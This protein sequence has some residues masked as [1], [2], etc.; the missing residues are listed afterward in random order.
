MR[1][2]HVS[3]FLQGGAGRIIAALAIAQ[4]RAGH[5][6]VVVADSGQHAGYE[7]YPEYITCLGEAGV[8]FHTVTSTFT[9]DVA[10]NVR[11][12]RELTEL[13]GDRPVDIA[14]THAAIPTLVAR[15]AL[16]ARATPL[17]QTMH[18]WGIRKTA[19]QAATD[20]TLL[21]LT[22]AVVTPSAA[23]RDTMLALGLRGTP[24][25]VVPYGLEEMPAGRAPDGTDRELFERLRA[26]GCPVVLCIGT[27]GERKNQ[28]LLVRALAS[29]DGVAAVFIGDGDSAPLTALARELDVASRV[30]VL[31]YRA[32][33]SRYL[34]LADA[35]V[36]PSR[37]EGLPIVVLEALRAGVPVVGSA[38][39]EIAEAVGDGQ[40]GFLFAPDDVLDL[41]A[42]LAGAL[43]PEVRGGVRA[44]ARQLFESRYR[45][46][47]MLAAYD[48]IYAQLRHQTCS[49][50]RQH[51]Q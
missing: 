17:L 44:R 12:V 15:L 41:A 47:R 51:V 4:R 36:L 26:S 48:E 28:A 6:V 29:L 20:I 46:D 2:L 40:T 38:I 24:V 10:L 32:D 16:S 23:A 35:L 25:H 50:E 19:E 27:I 34:P 37:N 11:A 18:G 33:A 8:R 30:H 43:A 5:D 21:G 39:P 1:I 45:A 7:S 31:G 3:T 42:A 13:L 9:R 14:H 22:D 49:A